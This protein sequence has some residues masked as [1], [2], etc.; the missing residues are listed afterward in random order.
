MVKN[1]PNL[2]TVQQG[3]PSQKKEEKS[4]KIL[5]KCFMV[6]LIPITVSFAINALINKD[7]K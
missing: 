6:N 2:R 3:D 4:K 5:T 7:T 1:I